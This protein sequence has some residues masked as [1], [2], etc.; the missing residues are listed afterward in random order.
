MTS[1]KPNITKGPAAQYEAAGEIIREVT[2][3]DGMGCLLAVRALTDPAALVLDVYRADAG[4]AVV[5][6]G[7]R[8]EA[9]RNRLNGR[10][11]W[12]RMNDDARFAMLRTMRTYGGGFA[13][14]LADAWSVAD[15]GNCTRLAESFPELIEAYRPACYSPNPLP[16]SHYSHQARVDAKLT[17][18]QRTAD[19]I[20]AAQAVCQSVD[21]SNPVA[22]AAQHAEDL[23]ALRAALGAVLS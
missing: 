1:R 17:E 9:N 5:A 20:R 11:M 7:L 21:G 22:T 19:L 18:R 14:H 15:Q 2:G 12:E 3:P 10:L 23:R 13:S 4:V 16:A 8:I 6:G